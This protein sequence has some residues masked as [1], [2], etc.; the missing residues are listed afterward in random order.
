[1]KKVPYFAIAFLAVIFAIA[2]CNGEQCTE[3]VY[4]L[5]NV[6]IPNSFCGTKDEVKTFEAEVEASAAAA[7]AQVGESPTVVCTKQ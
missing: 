5:N 6:P 3:C 7:G 2:A 4:T 1:M